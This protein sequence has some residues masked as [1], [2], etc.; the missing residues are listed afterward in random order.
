MILFSMPLVNFA[1]SSLEWGILPSFNL[2]KK[3]AKDWSVNLKTES[4]Q[5]LIKDGLNYD[6]LLTDFS[7]GATKK[8]GIDNLFTRIIEVYEN[9]YNY[10]PKNPE[11]SEK[12]LCKLNIIEEI[13]KDNYPVSKGII[14]LLLLE[15]DNYLLEVYLA[16]EKKIEKIKGF[17]KNENFRDNS[18]HIAAEL[19]RIAK[20]SIDDTIILEKEKK[21]NRFKEFLDNMMTHPI[22]GLPFLII[23]VW[24]G[25]YQFVGVFWIWYSGEPHRRKNSSK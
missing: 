3:L 23:V 5:S 18:Y 12:L 21:R 4:R 1:Q 10:C 16:S 6:Y 19:Y 7:F 14:S 22:W 9:R 20:K 2:N 15:G 24:I 11:F 17:L 25:L 13:I 8:I